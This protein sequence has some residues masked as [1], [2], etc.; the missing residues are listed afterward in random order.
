MHQV[1]GI[2]VGNLSYE[3]YLFAHKTIHAFKLY[4]SYYKYREYSISV[5]HFIDLA[6]L[7]WDKSI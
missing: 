5:L 6:K 2:E 7:I 1:D 4:S 3:I